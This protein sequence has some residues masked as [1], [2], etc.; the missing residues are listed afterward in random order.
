M[1]QVVTHLSEK[2]AIEVLE[3]KDAL[4]S[5]SF[6]LDYVMLFLR[7]RHSF[8]TR[9]KGKIWRR[10]RRF[11]WINRLNH[12]IKRNQKKNTK[13]ADVAA[14]CST[15]K[16]SSVHAAGQ[17]WQLRSRPFSKT[18]S[19]LP[20]GCGLNLLVS[21]CWLASTIL[22]I[23]DRT[24]QPFRKWFMPRGRFLWKCWSSASLIEWSASSTSSHFFEPRR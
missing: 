4:V 3:R 9:E 13:N 7:R 6:C 5:S 21:H 20:D 2:K 15:G 12:K 16:P 18:V 19:L 24:L 23:L 14:H 8:W 10:G 17:R 11:S 1:T 22:Y